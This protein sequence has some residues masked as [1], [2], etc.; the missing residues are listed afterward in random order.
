MIE[1]Y[2]DESRP[3]TIFSQNSV[4]RYMIIGGIWVNRS[5]R[6]KV[7][8]KINYLKKK[9]E[10]HG[11]VKWTKV[12]PMSLEFYK[13]VLNYFFE[14][15]NLRFRCIVVDSHKLDL[16]KYHNS[17]G[18]LGFY[19]FYYQLLNKWIEGNEVYRIYLDNKSNKDG[20]RLHELKS[21]LNK[22]SFSSIESVLSVNSNESIFVE[23]VDIL[24]GAVG[25]K[26]NNCGRSEAKNTL[27]E[28]IEN[29][30]GGPISG[31][32]PTERKFNVFKI[33]LK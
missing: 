29:N 31:T 12:S 19:K 20:N 24:I 10:I 33:I 32:A 16:K 22:V 9:Y 1:V 14:N 26:Y 27:V 15:E 23:I 11:E 8:N 5:E 4:D 25:Y 6:K 2:C 21:I 13:E 30:I 28:I 17:D 18:E 3:E 7:K